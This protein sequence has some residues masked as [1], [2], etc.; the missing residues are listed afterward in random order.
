MTTQASTEYEKYYV[1]DQSKMAVMATIGLI[2]SIFG[3]ASVMNDKTFGQQVR[4]VFPGVERKNRGSR[5]N[6]Y[7]VYTGLVSHE[8]VPDGAPDVNPGK[9]EGHV[10]ASLWQ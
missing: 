5:E 10:D 2:L 3:A 4:R 7:Y 9:D 1:P 8:D 6:R